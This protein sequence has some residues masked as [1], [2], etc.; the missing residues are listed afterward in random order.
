[1]KGYSYL[2]AADDKLATPASQLLLP[3][4]D[5]PNL[6]SRGPYTVF[7]EDGAASAMANPPSVSHLHGQC[8]AAQRPITE[9]TKRTG[10]RISGRLGVGVIHNFKTEN[11]WQ[12]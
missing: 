3:V 2:T 5:S 7:G 12:E 4:I 6:K 10:K 11:C 8:K 9:L 1:L